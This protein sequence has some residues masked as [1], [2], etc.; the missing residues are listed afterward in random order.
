VESRTD[1]ARDDVDGA[2][3]AGDRPVLLTTIGVPL[4]DGAVRFATESAVEAGQSLVVANVTQLEPLSLSVRMGYDALEE[5]TPDVSASL[6]R[7]VE[8]ATSLGLEVERLRIRSPRPVSALLQLVSERR[9]G[10]LVF[11]PDRARLGARAYRSAERAIREHAD[12]LVWMP[13]DPA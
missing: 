8:L 3:G 4:D 7:S 1:L 5:L 12:C 11:G 13:P 9:P 10:L 2:I 6:R